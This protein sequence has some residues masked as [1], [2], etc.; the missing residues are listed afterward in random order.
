MVLGNSCSMCE[1]ATS[2][3]TRMMEEPRQFSKVWFLKPLDEFTDDQNSMRLESAQS[4]SPMA[5]TTPK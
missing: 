2:Q 1:A 5:D 4:K 3:G